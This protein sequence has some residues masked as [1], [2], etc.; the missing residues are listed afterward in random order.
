M[1]SFLRLPLLFLLLFVPT[2]FAQNLTEEP[3]LQPL[4][5]MLLPEEAYSISQNDFLPPFII[6]N[7]GGGSISE[8]F[9]SNGDPFELVFTFDPNSQFYNIS[10]ISDDAIVA[11]LTVSA[12]GFLGTPYF[13]RYFFDILNINTPLY[14]N[15]HYDQFQSNLLF[16]TLHVN[17]S[18]PL[19]FDASGLNTH[20]LIPLQK[21]SLNT[22]YYAQAVALGDQEL[23]LS[24]AYKIDIPY[25]NDNGAQT[26]PISKWDFN[27]GAGLTAFDSAGSNDGTLQNGVIWT[28]DSATGYA[29]EFDGIDDFV[30]VPNTLSLNLLNNFTVEAWI[31]LNRTHGDSRYD[32]FIGKDNAYAFSIGDNENSGKLSF[33]LA[34][35]SLCS[36]YC[37]TNIIVPPNEW[38]HIIVQYDGDMVKT[39][40]DGN[41]VHSFQQPPSNQF[42][43]NIFSIGARATLNG[44]MNTF[45]GIIDDVIIYD[46]A[47]Y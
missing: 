46:F 6:T 22:T 23:F 14:Y 3:I 30:S 25:G 12:V 35:S 44:P 40:L 47:K 10:Q 37:S 19:Y 34:G 17:L 43:S 15:I 27:E 16:G 20:V 11:N 26:L 41:L 13:L 38:H 31:K 39:F 5:N 36:N 7:L 45:D 32:D 18:T 4:K 8:F 28:S 42:S 21:K 1:L 33:V 2:V 24:D 9:K 29:L